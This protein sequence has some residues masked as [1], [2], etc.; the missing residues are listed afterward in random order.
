MKELFKEDQAVPT[1]RVVT[2]EQ[3]DGYFS[4]YTHF[5]IH[6]EMLKVVVVVTGLTPNMM[7]FHGQDEVRTDAYHRFITQNPSIFKDKVSNWMR[8]R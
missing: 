8:V 5:S 4:T 3:E 2:S 7:Y 1:K 6:E